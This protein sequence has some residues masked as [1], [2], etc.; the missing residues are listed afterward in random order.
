MGTLDTDDDFLDAC[1][2]GLA[3]YAEDDETAALRPLFPDGDP[4]KAPEWEAL[5]GG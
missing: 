5:F 2:G 1:D 4:T 3:E